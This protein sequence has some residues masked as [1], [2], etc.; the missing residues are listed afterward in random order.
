MANIFG[1]ASQIL[2]YV[3]TAPFTPK[4]SVSSTMQLLQVFKTGRLRRKE[5]LNLQEKRL[6]HLISHAY[7]HV[8][9]YRRLF[10]QAKVT[11]ND[12]RS[13]GDLQKLPV[14]TKFMLKS[15]PINDRLAANIDPRRLERNQT[16]GSSGVPLQ[17]YYRLEDSR[18]LGIIGLRAWLENGMTRFDR[19]VRLVHPSLFSNHFQHNLSLLAMLGIGR[20]YDISV[21]KDYRRVVP[22]LLS[23]HPHVLEGYASTLKMLVLAIKDLGVAKLRP[24][25]VMTYAE[26]LDL[27]TRRVIESVLDTDLIDMYGAHECRTIAWECRRHIGYHINADSLILEFLK[28]GEQVSSGALGKVVVTNLFSFAM[29]FIRYELGDLAIPLDEECNC[30]CT[31]PLLKM[32]VGRLLD[33]IVL[34]N[35]ELVSPF[36]IRQAFALRPEI[37]MFKVLQKDRYDIEVLLVKGLG[38][39]ENTIKG[40]RDELKAILGEE[41]NISVSCVDEISVPSGRKYKQIESRVTP[42]MI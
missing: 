28:D 17:V 37:K 33:F 23:L 9:L 3:A 40:I 6:R 2:G 35:G 19:R 30:G 14:V 1:Y 16:S 25:F 26:V 8:P 34:P 22:T 31:L 11:P 24:K 21:P 18:Q 12:I 27:S 38:F 4:Q 29:P 41:L 20:T 7:A 42:T 5:L 32:V 36:T 39:S 15:T 10:R 13:L